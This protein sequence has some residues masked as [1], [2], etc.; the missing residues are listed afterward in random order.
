[1]KETDSH[2]DETIECGIPLLNHPNPQND[3]QDT[4]WL[5]HAERVR[6]VT[7]WSKRVVIL[8]LTITSILLCLLF[9]FTCPRCLFG[10]LIFSACL[11]PLIH[12]MNAPLWLALVLLVMSGWTFTA[13][14]LSV[15]WHSK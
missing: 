2:T 12:S 11:C 3:R 4:A 1:M 5:V 10:V 7:E 8:L 15:S 13:G 14:N 6:S 9:Y